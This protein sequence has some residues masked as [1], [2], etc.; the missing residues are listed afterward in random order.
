MRIRYRCLEAVRIVGRDTQ[1]MSGGDVRSHRALL[2]HVSQLLDFPVTY[3]IAQ[4]YQILLLSHDYNATKGNH[5]SA[6][7]Q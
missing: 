1:L 7:L 6:I 2:Y 3:L 4:H 5:D